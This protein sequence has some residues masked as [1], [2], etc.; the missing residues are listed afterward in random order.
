MRRFAGP[1]LW[2]EVA[3]RIVCTHL[4]VSH[5]DFLHH[6]KETYSAE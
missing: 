6:L 1:H 4:I 2:E 5:I 3:L